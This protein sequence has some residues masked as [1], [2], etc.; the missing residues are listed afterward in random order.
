MNVFAAAPET[1]PS[2]TSNSLNVPIADAD[3]LAKPNEAAIAMDSKVF[4]IS[5]SPKV[6]TC[7]QPVRPR[8]I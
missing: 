8:A 1:L 7:T 2:V 5:N 3:A 6:V 4:F